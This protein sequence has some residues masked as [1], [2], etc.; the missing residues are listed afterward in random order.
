MI[1]TVKFQRP[2]LLKQLEGGIPI[3]L[4]PPVGYFEGSIMALLF[5]LMNTVVSVPDVGEL[6]QASLVASS[7][8]DP[9]NW[10]MEEKFDGI[11]ACYNPQDK[12]M[13]HY[14]TG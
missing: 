13:Y 5:L 10:W 4:E 9:T 11:R 14:L 2:E 6:M 12:M 3:P 7:T 8:F 1:A